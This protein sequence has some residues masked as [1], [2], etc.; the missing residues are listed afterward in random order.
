ML[1][2]NGSLAPGSGTALYR[3]WSTWGSFLSPRIS[4]LPAG[5]IAI[6]SAGRWISP[7]DRIPAALSARSLL[8]RLALGVQF[9]WMDI[10]WYP[11]GVVPL[12]ALDWLFR[13]RIRPK[14]QV[15]AAAPSN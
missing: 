4:P 7:T 6:G 12:V 1:G 8:A 14:Q 11:A 10:A 15:R 9:D 3:R 5:A 2:S 13:A